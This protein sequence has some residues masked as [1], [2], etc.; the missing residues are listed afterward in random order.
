MLIQSRFIVSLLLVS[1][2]LLLISAQNNPSPIQIQS[3]DRSP[4]E[5]WSCDD[6][7]CEEDIEGF[8]ARIQV[9]E[10]FTLSHVGQFPGQPMQ[11]TV[12]ADARLYGTILE[13][14][15]RRGAVY[16]L[17][18]EGRL[19]RISPRFW[20]P[21]GI[22]FNDEGQLYVSGRVNPESVG[23]VWR[24]ESD[25]SAEIVVDDLPCCYSLDNQPNGMIFGDDGLLYLGVGSTSDR[26]EPSDPAHERYATPQPFEA[27]ILKIDVQTGNVESVA[28]GIR[29]PYD[30]AFTSDGQ[31][32]ATDNGLLSGQGDR[33]LQVNEGDNYG[34]PYWRSRRCPE[35]PPREGSDAKDDWLLLDDYTLPRGMVAYNGTQFPANMLDTLLVAFWNG[36]DHTQGIVW[37]DPNDSQLDDDDYAPQPFVTGLI[38]PVDVTVAPDGSL[39]IADFVYGHVWRVSYTDDAETTQSS[40]LPPIIATITSNTDATPNELPPVIATVVSNAE[41]N[42]QPIPATPTVNSMGFAFTTATPSN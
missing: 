38:R 13:K 20:S 33:L 37:I 41:N 39:V 36:T 29:N 4:S 31:L 2:W 35:C 27:S 15:T 40:D 12:G 6:F 26:G 5:G 24:V 28:G 10:G 1:S 14:G 32:Y 42:T 3:A 21:V 7:P 19:E 22:A 23:A 30:L 9:A 34:F 11:I 25:L 18:D 8:L 16:A 17:D